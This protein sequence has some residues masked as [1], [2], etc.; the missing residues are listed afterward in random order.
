MS[1]LR[2]LGEFIGFYIFKY[3]VNKQ[4]DSFNFGKDYVSN[5]GVKIVPKCR[6]RRNE[7]NGASFVQF[8]H[9]GSKI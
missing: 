7:S 9:P 8:R 1:V 6:V 5:F 3:C 4:L 2:L